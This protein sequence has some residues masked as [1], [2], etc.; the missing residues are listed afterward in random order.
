MSL[1]PTISRTCCSNCLF[2]S[3]ERV[4]SSVIVVRESSVSLACSIVFVSED[5]TGID[6]VLPNESC[7]SVIWV[8]SM[9]AESGGWIG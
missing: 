5:V 2:S 3:S 9:V 6:K 8:K 1:W 7:S 4:L